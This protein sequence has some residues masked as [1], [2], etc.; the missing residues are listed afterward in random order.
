M[1]AKL[2]R[3]AELLKNDHIQA[4]TC[5]GACIIILALAFKKVLHQEAS[6]LENAIPGYIFTLYEAA[7]VK[8]KKRIISRPLLWNIAMLLATG[9]IILRRAL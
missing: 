8:A 1:R 6:I 4:S 2:K 7:R 9:I 5:S 3:L